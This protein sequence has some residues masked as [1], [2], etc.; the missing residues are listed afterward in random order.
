MEGIQVN[1]DLSLPQVNSMD[2]LKAIEGSGP[3]LWGKV[4]KLYEIDIRDV[5]DLHQ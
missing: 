3:P 5:I 4:Q 1:S 2:N